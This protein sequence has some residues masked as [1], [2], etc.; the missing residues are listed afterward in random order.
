M[1]NFEQWFSWA[2]TEQ[3]IYTDDPP[4]KIAREAFN[5]GREFDLWDN[6]YDVP[7]PEWLPT[8]EWKFGI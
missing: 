1:S 8:E 3:I 6:G 2:L 5:A 7:R 4:E